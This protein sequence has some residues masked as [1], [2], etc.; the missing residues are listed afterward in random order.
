MTRVPFPFLRGPLRKSA[1][2]IYR[3]QDDTVLTFPGQPMGGW[4]RVDDLAPCSEMPFDLTDHPQG[5]L[6]DG[7]G[8]VTVHS[9]D[10]DVVGITFAELRRVATYIQNRW[11]LCG[12]ITKPCSGYLC[13]CGV[14][15]VI[16]DHKDPS[17]FVAT[18]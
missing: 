9:T 16:P 17:V 7:A 12:E 11:R 10:P 15:F 4:V 14:P 18:V 5:D 2:V 8:W 6:P 13:E 3:P 1:Y